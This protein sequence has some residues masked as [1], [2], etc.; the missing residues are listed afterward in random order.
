[1]RATSSSERPSL[2]VVVPTW[3]EAERLPRLF[4][5]LEAQGEAR[6][7]RVIVADGGSTDGTDRLVERHGAELVR[8]PRGRG[9]QLAR[10]AERASE[11]L[12]LFLHADGHVAPGALAALRAAFGDPTLVA[13]GL[14]QTIDHEGRIFRWIERA[15]NRRV[16]LG[17]IYG[18]S[19]LGVRRSE[20]EAVGG[21]AELP[22]F[23][24]LDL[25]RRLRRRGPIALVADG[26]LHVSP[27]RWLAEGP[28]RRTVR[29]WILTLAWSLGVDPARL[30][31]YYRPHSAAAE[32]P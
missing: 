29:N 10:G 9:L 16:R 30:V 5:S 15:A 8:A 24:D 19:G 1:M 20:Y 27:R 3:N 21:F 32:R 4:A 22:L 26:V 11:D 18:D 14:R 12:V 23:E 28:V 13:V 31:R 7:E 2:A 17:W 6:P 25:S